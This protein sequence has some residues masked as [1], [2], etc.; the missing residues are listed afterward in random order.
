MTFPFIERKKFVFVEKD[1][2]KNFQFW[3]SKYS[4]QCINFQ[5]CKKLLCILDFDG[6][7]LFFDPNRDPP[8]YLASYFKMRVFCC[9][10]NIQAWIYQKVGFGIFQNVGFWNISKSGFSEYSKKWVFGIF[11][12]VGFGNIPNS[13]FLEYFEKLMGFKN[14]SKSVF[15]GYFKN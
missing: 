6:V 2:E 11:Q 8:N 7:Q 5:K 12:K 3:P 4:L 9:F 13:G 14:I 15:W 10:W 1:P